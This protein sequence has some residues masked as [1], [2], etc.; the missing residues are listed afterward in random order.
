[1]FFDRFT[2]LRLEF[3]YTELQPPGDASLRKEKLGAP[4]HRTG[5]DNIS[6]D[7]RMLCKKYSILQGLEMGWRGWKWCVPHS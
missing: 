1:M 6:K 5:L 4:E 7:Q 2:S 3:R